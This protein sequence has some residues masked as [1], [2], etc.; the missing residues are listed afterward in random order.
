MAYRLVGCGRIC[1]SLVFTMTPA[2]KRTCEC[3][4]DMVMAHWNSSTDRIIFCP[5]HAHA[6]SLFKA[7]SNLVIDIKLD[8]NPTYTM[9]KLTD[10]LAL[11][12]ES[13]P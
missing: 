6:E 7:A 2:S 9:D 5:L 10:I 12:G 3:R 4:P 1:N 11:C 13:K 8:K